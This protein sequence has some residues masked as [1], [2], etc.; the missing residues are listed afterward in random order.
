MHP[1]LGVNLWNYWWYYTIQSQTGQF[2][3]RVMGTG[4]KQ[5]SNK[6]KYCH[7]QRVANSGQHKFNYPKNIPDNLASTWLIGIPQT[8]T[9]ISS[10]LDWSVVKTCWLALLSSQF[11]ISPKNCTWRRVRSLLEERAL[12]KK[13]MSN[14]LLIPHPSVRSWGKLTVLNKDTLRNVGSSTPNMVNTVGH[15]IELIST[16]KTLRIIF[17]VH[18]IQ[19]STEQVTI[20]L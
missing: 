10:F 8:I 11:R 15:T 1:L 6:H 9:P 17:R 18:T 19:R 14:P 3:K 16:I 4:T 12:E 13:K 5:P 7:N 2:Q 20:F